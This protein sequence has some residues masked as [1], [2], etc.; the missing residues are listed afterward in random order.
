MYAGFDDTDTPLG[1]KFNR[2]CYRILHARALQ[3][4]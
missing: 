2:Y 1:S 4:T 3:L